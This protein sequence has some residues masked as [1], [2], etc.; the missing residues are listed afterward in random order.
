MT[1]QGTEFPGYYGSK[2]DV[3]NRT[4]SYAIWALNEFP[5]YARYIPFGPAD[6]GGGGTAASLPV[7]RR[8]ITYD[9]A[10]R[11]HRHIKKGRS[12]LSGLIAYTLGAGKTGELATGPEP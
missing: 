10:D 12:V 7:G 2:G 11:A 1:S 9:D 5:F 6:G 8:L 3:S 4:L